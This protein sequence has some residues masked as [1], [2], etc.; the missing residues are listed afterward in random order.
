MP[1]PLPLG[2][3]GTRPAYRPEASWALGLGGGF[4]TLPTHRPDASLGPVRGG[5]GTLPTHRPRE[6]LAN[7]A[8]QLGVPG[9]MARSLAVLGRPTPRPRGLP[10]ADGALVLLTP[11]PGRLPVLSTCSLSGLDRTRSDRAEP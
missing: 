11:R 3:L 6:S 10:L 8:A 7:P 9:A 2:G 1:R 5:L 4:G